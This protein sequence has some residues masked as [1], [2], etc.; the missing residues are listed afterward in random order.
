MHPA[1]TIW[2]L[3]IV[4]VAA[5]V[6]W[7]LQLI[8][9]RRFREAIERRRARE[10]RRIQTALLDLVD[11]KAPAVVLPG[12]RRAV[13]RVAESLAALTEVLRGEEV[14]RIAA[15]LRQGGLHGQL[16]AS[17]R[18]GSKRSRQCSIEA[19]KVFPG[20]DTSDALRTISQEAD[21][22]ISLA[23]WKSLWALGEDV[24]LI[25]IARDAYRS[26]GRTLDRLELA[27]QIAARDPAK[28]IPYALDPVVS[29]PVRLKLVESI[30]ASGRTAAAP[31]LM[32][33]AQSEENPRI[34]AAALR[35]LGRF[36]QCFT[37]DLLA[38]ALASPDWE[39]RSEAA[40]AVALCRSAS[41]AGRLAELL[42]DDV[43]TVRV[44]AGRAL[45]RMAATGRRTLKHVVETGGSRPRR[46][47]GFML[48]G[49]GAG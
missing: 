1:M 21:P 22:T 29:E 19:L 7:M 25:D 30:A 43:W 23:A 8:L 27:G 28:A 38:D 16:L 35:G 40:S 14:E 11:A 49:G 42:D 12:G 15:A 2:W 10:H 48:S 24:A 3:S 37:D 32:R 31:A 45:L 6:A 33:L 39:V 5:A 4:L 44:N 20:Q 46:V 9:V 13:S 34:R 47:A 41:Q 17:A 26:R 36:T 18:H